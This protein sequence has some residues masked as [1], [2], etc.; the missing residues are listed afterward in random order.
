MRDDE[1][2][3]LS[4][5][6]E[7]P[8]YAEILAPFVDSLQQTSAAMQACHGA[9]DHSH[10]RVLAHRLKGSGTGYGFPGLTERA[11]ELESAIKADATES[12]PARLD[13]LLSYIERVSLS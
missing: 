3:I 4:Q 8:D 11:A 7:D 9:G 1:S 2:P 5:F 13:A 10:L 12:I 6:S